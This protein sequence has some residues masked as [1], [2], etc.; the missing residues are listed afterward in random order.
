MSIHRDIANAVEDL[1]RC[2]V[3][4]SLPDGS[5]RPLVDVRIAAMRDAQN[6]QPG[7]QRYDGN[8]VAVSLW[9]H[10]HEREVRE[11]E[12]RDLD[13]DGETIELHDPTGEAALRPDKGAAALRRLERLARS[14]AS[15][16]DAV[17]NELR[18]WDAN[19]VTNDRAGIGSCEDCGRYCDGTKNDRL[20][21]VGEHRYCNTCR[22]RAT[23]FDPRRTA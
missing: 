19:V 15:D 5:T 17:I 13:C 2:L 8:G 14:L 12:E 1:L 11:C 9:C 16:A 21:P 22:M 20:R 23:R 18:R 4:T 3:P 6:G 7:A 10:L